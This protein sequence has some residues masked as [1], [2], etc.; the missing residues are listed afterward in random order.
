MIRQPPRSTRTDTLFPYTTLFRSDQRGLARS[1]FAHEVGHL[2]R[3]DIDIDS[4]EHADG[5]LPGHEFAHDAA[6]ANRSFGAAIAQ[7]GR[8]GAPLNTAAGSV[9][10]TLRK[11]IQPVSARLSATATRL[12]S[13]HGQGR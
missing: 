10:R 4:V 3:G 12:I 8:G 1:G 6:R 5:V 7:G 2:A 11:A 13:G 9:L